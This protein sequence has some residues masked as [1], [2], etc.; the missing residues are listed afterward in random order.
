MECKFDGDL[1]QKYIDKTIDPLEK[2]FVEE[3]LKVCKK[4]RKDL[5]QFKLLYYELEGLE[6]IQEVPDEL[7]DIRNMVLDNIFTE[8]NKYGIRDFI[9]QQKKTFAL[10]SEFT[11]YIPGKRLIRKSL[12]ATGSILGTATKKSAKYGLKIIQERI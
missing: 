11:E 12:K 3:H 9:N 1:I 7:E 4:C 2:I 8:S 10:A 5:T 6:E